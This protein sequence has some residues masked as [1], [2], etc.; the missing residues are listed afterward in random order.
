MTV[1]RKSA[2]SGKSLKSEDA[3]RQAQRSGVGVISER[4]QGINTN[5]KSTEGSKIAKID[6]ENDVICIYV[7]V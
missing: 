1:I 7:D 6:R 4:K 5:H 2:P 3:L